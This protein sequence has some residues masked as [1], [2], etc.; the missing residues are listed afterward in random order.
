MVLISSSLMSKDVEYF[1]MNLQAI[2]LHLLK[3]IHFI[4][5][6][7]DWVLWDLDINLVSY[8]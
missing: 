8:V 7:I 5:M 4:N 6:F 1:F 2:L 3:N